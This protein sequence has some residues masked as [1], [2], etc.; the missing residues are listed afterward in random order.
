MMEGE[1]K[2]LWVADPDHGFRLGKLVDIG[3]ET[4]TIEP[5]DSPG[6]VIITFLCLYISN[7][8]LLISFII[9][10]NSSYRLCISVRGVRKQ[11]CRRQLCSHVFE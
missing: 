8:I 4:L 3:A 1:G 5:F 6:R 2:K 9:A 11:R 10:D 7:F